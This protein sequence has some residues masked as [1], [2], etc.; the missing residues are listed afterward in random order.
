MT[1]NIV[2]ENGVT[3]IELGPDY[4]RI[5]AV[6]YRRRE[7]E[8]IGAVRAADP[9]KV[10]VDLSQT[11]FFSTLFLGSLINVWDGLKKRNGQL[12]L[13]GL[14]EFCREIIEITH[15][16]SLWRLYDTRDQAVADLAA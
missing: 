13:S 16:D 15:L 8:L 7:E 10:V 14:S 11:E 6:S 2:V 12:V 1:I 5:E 9:P 3:I 4:R